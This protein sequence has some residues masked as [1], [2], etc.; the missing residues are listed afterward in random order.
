MVNAALVAKTGNQK[1]QNRKVLRAQHVQVTKVSSVGVSGCGGQTTG[2]G[3]KDTGGLIFL[4][5]TASTSG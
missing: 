1:F 3:S 2:L 4:S 5:C